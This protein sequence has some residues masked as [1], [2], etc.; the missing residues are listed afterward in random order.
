[1][2]NTKFDTESGPDI[3]INTSDVTTDKSSKNKDNH[4]NENVETVKRIQTLKFTEEQFW[5]FNFQKDAGET[6]QIAETV[7][8]TG[9][10]ME[11]D[12]ETNKP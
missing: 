9:G 10:K 6:N 2:A 11:N 8:G 1:M 4:D 7:Y 3:N 5:N 12:P